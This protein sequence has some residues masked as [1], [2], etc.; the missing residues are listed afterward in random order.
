MVTWLQVA[1]L[2]LDRQ[3]L[4]QRLPASKLV[5]VVGEMVGIHA[6]VMSAAELQ[7]NA[8]LEGLRRDDVRDALHEKRAL[9]KTWSMRGTLHLHTSADLWA[10]VAA[11]P[12]RDN[13]GSAPWLKY[14]K[15]T[16]ERRDAV[17]A[18]IATVLD[19]TPMT[20]VE[21]ADAV[22]AELGD[23]ALGARLTSGW[24]ELLKPAAGRGLLAFGPE[25]GR[26]VTFIDPSVWLGAKPP[27][28][29]AE[30][31]VALGELLGRWLGVFPGAGRDAAA[32]W[33]GVQSRPTMQKAIDAAGIAVADLDV[34]GSKVWAL[35]ADV[36]R[37]ESGEPPVGVRL[38]PN[39][40]PYVND[41]P[42]R[43]AA[44]LPVASHDRVYR[45]AGWISPVVVVDG[46]V[47]GTWEI[48]SGK[49]G[50][51]VVRP[52]GRWRS[53]ARSELAAEAERIAEFLD[54]P[55]KVSVERSP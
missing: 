27:R 15:I 22:G 13:T 37:L 7:L 35:T 42:R 50:G 2:R 17:M 4:T 40:D 44:L 29:S 11:Y 38:L 10:F 25:A 55:L 32:R 8:R 6:Q 41:L 45:T 48:E 47:L 30:P 16:R 9:V 51:I 3:H 46:R 1:A 20:K 36:R 33:W 49:R 54:R 31:L 18:A 53:G 39:F 28:T 14:F 23:G 52:F 34:D 43:T 5:D 24:G 19:G 12:T 21:L 26:N